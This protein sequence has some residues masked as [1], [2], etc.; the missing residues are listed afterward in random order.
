[1]CPS[2]S[3]P[4]RSEASCWR[5]LRV[6]AR[7]VHVRT[8]APRSSTLRSRRRRAPASSGARSCRAPARTTAR[9]RRGV[10]SLIEPSA[11]FMRSWSFVCSSCESS[12]VRSV[13]RCRSTKA[14]CLDGLLRGR[15][16]VD[17]PVVQRLEVA[18]LRLL[19]TRARA[20]TRAR[21][22]RRTA[23]PRL[24]ARPRAWSA[25]TQGLAR[26]AAERSRPGPSCGR[27]SARSV[28]GCR[29]PPPPAGPSSACCR[30]PS[31][32]ACS[33]WISGSAASSNFRPSSAAVYFHVLRSN[34]IMSSS[35]GVDGAERSAA[36]RPCVAA[37]LR[38][39]PPTGW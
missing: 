28:A 25:S 8:P 30:L 18:H 39:G 24:V 16:A 31:S 5:R 7:L 27:A 9:R 36:D 4:E 13:S 12:R 35:F 21:P 34:R 2:S 10:R 37:A 33:I 23:A 38:A 19:V 20:R 6:D 1:M 15:R 11:A 14:F 17:R 32:I 26:R 29:S 22:R 3:K